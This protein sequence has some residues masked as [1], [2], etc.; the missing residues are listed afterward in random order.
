MA[1]LLHPEL[2]PERLRDLHPFPFPGPG[3]SEAG[4]GEGMAK[5]FGYISL[6][7]TL[8]WCLPDSG[9]GAEGLGIVSGREH[10]G[11]ADGWLE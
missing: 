7:N 1:R 6:A 5:P 3:G 11:E 10:M 9:V 2:R 4:G 8:S